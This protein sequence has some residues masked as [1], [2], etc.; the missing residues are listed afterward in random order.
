MME[1]P[2]YG[3]VFD[4]LVRKLKKIKKTKEEMIKYCMRKVFRYLS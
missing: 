4:L 2:Q 3:T 1:D